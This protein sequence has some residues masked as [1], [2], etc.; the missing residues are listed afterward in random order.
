MNIDQGISKTE[1]MP[2]GSI[3]GFS[4]SK[5]CKFLGKGFASFITYDTFAVLIFERFIKLNINAY[6]SATCKKRKSEIDL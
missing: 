3:P 5:G 4:E 2:D 6:H 1:R